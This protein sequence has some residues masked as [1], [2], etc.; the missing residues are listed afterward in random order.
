MA[1]IPEAWIG[2][3]PIILAY[4]LIK[5]PYNEKAR[6]TSVTLSSEAKQWNGNFLKSKRI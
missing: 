2:H 5:L 3:F 4:N 6:I 1:V